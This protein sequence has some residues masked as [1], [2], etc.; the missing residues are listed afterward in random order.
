[1][2]ELYSGGS[3]LQTIDTAR[4]TRA[5]RSELSL[6][7]ETGDDCSTKTTSVVEETAFD[8]SDISF[9]TEWESLYQS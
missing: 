1:M 7:F 6:A 2:I 9:V 8:A 4:R 5:Y 3:L